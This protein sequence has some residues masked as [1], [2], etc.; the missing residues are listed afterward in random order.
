M[1]VQSCT[2]IGLLATIPWAIIDMIRYLV[3]SDREFA[4]RYARDED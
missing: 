3:M 4:A 2:V 1:V